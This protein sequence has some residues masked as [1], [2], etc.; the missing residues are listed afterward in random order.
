MPPRKYN[1]RNFFFPI[2]LS[3]KLPRKYRLI[4][5]PRICQKLPWTK[6]LLTMV[7]GKCEKYAGVKPRKKIMSG[8]REVVIKTRT[9]IAIKNQIAFKL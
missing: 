6:R 4:I 8:L 7:Q 5:L 3:K 9:F 2:S 1:V